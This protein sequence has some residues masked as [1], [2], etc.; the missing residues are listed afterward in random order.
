MEN[1]LA[2][3]ALKGIMAVIEVKNEELQK[4]RTEH[5]TTLK[6][7]SAMID[8]Y[9]KCLTDY[10]TLGNAHIQLLENYKKLEAELIGWKSR[11]LN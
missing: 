10:N 3:T 7:M 9:Q 1:D 2:D 11:S 6:Q 4:E 8:E 5:N